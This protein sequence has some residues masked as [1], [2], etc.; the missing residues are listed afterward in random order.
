MACSKP[1][2]FERLEEARMNLKGLVKSLRVS[3]PN[4]PM[5]DSVKAL[6]KIPERKRGG[7]GKRE[8]ERGGKGK[9]GENKLQRTLF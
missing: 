7:E 8:E 3:F 4:R 5:V 2:T 1:H 9:L 6:L